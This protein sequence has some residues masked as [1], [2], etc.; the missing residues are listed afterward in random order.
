MKLSNEIREFILPK[1]NVTESYAHRTSSKE[2]AEIIMREGFRFSDS[3]QKTTDQIIDDLVYI[4]YW[5][6][7]RKHYGGY[8]VI[9]AISQKVIDE[10]LKKIPSSIEVQQALSNVVEA[11]EDSDDEPAYLLPKQYIKGY[12]ERETGRIVANED[13]NPDFFPHVLNLKQTR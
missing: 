1:R 9:I 3:F 5:D 6:S 13:F 7:L 11:S 12:L 4:R 8:I 2:V 10:V